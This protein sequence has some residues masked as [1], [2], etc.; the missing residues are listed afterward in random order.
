MVAALIH[1]DSRVFDSKYFT[2]GEAN[3]ASLSYFKGDDLAADAFVDK[4]A[5]RDNQDR[6]LELTPDDMHR[7]LASVF[8]KAESAH[9]NAMSESEIYGLFR[10]FEYVIPQGS[11]MHVLGNPYSYQ[12][13]SN[14]Y[15]LGSPFDS[16]A[17]IMYTD[18]EL[19]HILKR[20]GGVG[21]DISPIRPKNMRAANAAKTT[22]GIGVFMERYSN[23]TREVGQ[24]GRR[25]ALIETIDIR[26]PEIETFINIK[27]DKKKVTGANISIRLTDAFMRAV[28]ADGP[29]TQQWPVD[30]PNPS[31]TRVVRARAIWDQI[32]D[33]AWD[34][35]EPGLFFWDTVLR[36]TPSD[37]YA[38][39][40]YRSVGTNPCGEIPLSAYDACRLMV[41]NTQSHVRAPHTGNSR[42]DFELFGQHVCQAQRL[43]DDLVDI[44]LGL[45][46]RIIEK[47]ATDV[48]PEHIKEIEA[49]LWQ[50]VRSATERGRRTGLGITALGDTL[51]ALGIRYGSPESIQM[52]EEIYKTLAI[53][54]ERSSCILAHERGAFPA[55]DWELEAENPY[56]NRVWE[57]APDVKQMWSE[58]GRRNIATTTTAPTGSVSVLTQ[59]TSGIEPVFM[60]KYKRRRKLNGEDANISVDFVDPMGDKWHEYEVYHP[61]FS[62][63]MN[64]TGKL[65]IEESPYWKATSRDVDWVASVDLQAAAQKWVAHSI[66]K[67]CNLPKDA[68]RDIVSQVYMRAWKAGCKGF[69]VY[70][71]GCRD[72][73][74]LESGSSKPSLSPRPA[75]FVEHHAP[76]RPEQLDCRIHTTKTREDGKSQEWVFLVGIMA[77]RPYEVFGGRS[78][79]LQLPA[80]A[81]AGKITK[82]MPSG[83]LATYDLILDT[84]EVQDIVSTFANPTHGAFTRVIS[85]SLRHG[86]PIQYVV[87]QLLKEDSVELHSFAKAL[88]R[89]LKNYITNGT[90]SSAVKSCPTCGSKDIVYTEG[91]STCKGCGHSKCG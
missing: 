12:S 32:I 13:A 77:G 80:S 11:P 23:T 37:C 86:A 6:F 87:E 42:F 73:V 72:G 30:S 76:K 62:Q 55:F 56:L 57:A 4:Y 16:Y 39:V 21:I 68:T 47:V 61:G 44:E 29:F 33:A 75:D 2:R 59:T 51:A 64:A 65:D 50:K 67:T 15:V 83:G 35:A 84:M 52:T 85:L 49:N 7:R 19:A 70:R 34:N 36:E 31:V 43:M 9:P 58:Y 17:G 24:G 8:Y 78:G 60:V 89:I 82:V 40:G 69:T 54:S 79:D 81:Q 63:W 25:G 38:S 48:E 74:L 27:R 71:E 1:P 20:R 14:C 22:D 90:R 91:C 26:H 46:D 45:I 41:V 88:A 28:E 3:K 10:N 53:N 5:L 18:Q 66:S